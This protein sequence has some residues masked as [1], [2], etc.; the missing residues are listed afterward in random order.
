[1]VSGENPANF[2]IRNE[3]GAIVSANTLVDISISMP[4]VHLFSQVSK[5]IRQLKV[6]TYLPN[7]LC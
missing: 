2:L 3:S 6:R 4:A 5:L 1:M 7:V